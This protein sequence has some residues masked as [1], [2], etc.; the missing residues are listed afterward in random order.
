M[1]RGDGGGS[2]PAGDGGADFAGGGVKR[3]CRIDTGEAVFGDAEGAKGLTEGQGGGDSRGA[4]TVGLEVND[5]T[6]AGEPE[7][8][9]EQVAHDDALGPGVTGSGRDKEAGY[10][11]G[12]ERRGEQEQK[13]I[14]RDQPGEES[15]HEEETGHMDRNLRRMPVLG[16]PRR[17]HYLALATTGRQQPSGQE[18]GRADRQ[19]GDPAVGDGFPGANRHRAHPETGWKLGIEDGEAGEPAGG[20]AGD[21]ASASRAPQWKPAP[22]AVKQTG[23]G[24]QPRSA[25]SAAAMSMLAEL[26]LP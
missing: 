3:A 17:R 22:K 16:V 20:G 19:S 15:L 12:E 6:V 13:Q 25:H 4:L 21:Q 8:G 7:G 14:E 2:V 1:R 9:E 24:G 11:D 5:G 23:P 10:G 26:V 18:C